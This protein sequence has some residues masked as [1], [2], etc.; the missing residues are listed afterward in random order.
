MSK[1]DFFE[2]DCHSDE[3]TLR[4]MYDEEGNLFYCHIFLDVQ[5]TFFKRALA[6]IKYAFG[7]K[8]KY[9]HF[10]EWIIQRDDAK[11]MIQM[12]EKIT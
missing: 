4:F 2:C 9:G 3:H 6:A 7:Y 8:C 11:R 10:G 12:L 1:S 5:A